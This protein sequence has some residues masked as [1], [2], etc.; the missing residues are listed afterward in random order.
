MDYWTAFVLGLAGSVHC[1]GM[2]G[3][4]ALSLPATSQETG[5]FMLSRL[6]YNLGRIL[7]YCVLGA[8]SGLIGQSLLLAGVQRWT[9]IVLGLLLLV[10]L[11]SSRKRA[12]WRP[13]TSQVESLKQRM[14]PLLRQ[15]SAAS[16]GL[17]GLLNGLLP[18]GLVYVA[19]AGATASSSLLGGAAYMTTFGL[20]TVPMLLAIS[21]SGRLVPMTWRVHLRKAIPVSVC[22][23]AMLLIVRGMRLW[24]PY[25]SPDLAGNCCNK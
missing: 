16:L 21:I 20:G 7:T 10:G 11:V 14:A 19:C 24:I 3:P 17:L 23:L 18:C 13:V 15:R 8:L 5:G 9:S 22:L 4:L 2:C 6:A 12:L 25:L 1:A